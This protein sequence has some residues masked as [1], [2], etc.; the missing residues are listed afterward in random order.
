M[1][2]GSMDGKG[3]GVRSI[4][5]IKEDEEEDEEEESSTQRTEPQDDLHTFREQWKRELEGSGTSA[6]RVERKKSKEDE[7]PDDCIHMKARE[8]F[9]Q[10]VTLEENGKLYEAIRFY[11]RA[12]SLVPDIERQTFVYT[13]KKFDKQ[14]KM[15]SESESEDKDE[16]GNTAIATE[17]EDDNEDISN[18][19]LKFARLK[20]ASRSSFSQ[21]ISSN[22]THIGS[23]PSEVV[24]YI[25]KWVVSPEL[26]LLSLESCSEVSR[27]FYLAARDEEIWRLVCL[28]I[29][30]PVSATTNLYSTWREMFLVRPRVSFNGC[31][32][33]KI[34]YIREGERG[35][36]DHESYRAWHVVE[37]H[38]F[39]RFFPGGRMLMVTSAETETDLTMKQMNNRTR[40]GIQGSMF[41]NYR[42]VDGV[43][44][45]V[46]CTKPSEAPKSR[47]TTRFRRSRHNPM[48]YYDAPQQEF[49][50]E[51]YIKG[52]NNRTLHWKNYSIVSK[53]KSGKEQISEVDVSNQINYPRMQF[54]SVDFYHFES[55]SPLL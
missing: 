25:L 36:Q 49:H 27:G 32:I 50:L 2:I 6:S 35:F 54:T 9:L 47:A 34:T 7:D 4:H 11:K 48:Q 16:N 15:R 5:V 14:E 20:C 38:R 28:R 18:L 8:L 40:C 1:N 33:S 3:K 29:W 10:G 12:E 46:L 45:C 17:A 52:S 41:G 39:L 31:Y 43:V 37:Y 19:C 51:F 44:V 26:D 23:L 24:N 53:Y 55:E 42:L 30:G 21:E 22:M 13:R